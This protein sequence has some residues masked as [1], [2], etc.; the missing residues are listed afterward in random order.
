MKNSLKFSSLIVLVCLSSPLW[1]GQNSE[2][3]EP[4]REPLPSR[5]WIQQNEPI[6]P[7]VTS[8][9]HLQEQ[10]TEWNRRRSFL[11]WVATIADDITM[12]E[13]LRSSKAFRY[14]GSFFRDFLSSVPIT[15]NDWIEDTRFNNMERLEFLKYLLDMGFVPLH[16]YIDLAT[17]FLQEEG[18]NESFPSKEDFVRLKDIC[19]SRIWP[20]D[21]SPIS[22]IRLAI[23]STPYLRDTGQTTFSYTD[24][25]ALFAHFGYT[26]E[27]FSTNDLRILGQFFRDLHYVPLWPDRWVQWEQ[28]IDVTDDNFETEVLE[29]SHNRPVIVLSYASSCPSCHL[30]VRIM[31]DL[32]K[33]FKDAFTLAKVYAHGNPAITQTMSVNNIPAITLYKKGQGVASLSG[34]VDV[35]RGGEALPPEMEYV[36]MKEVIRDILLRSFLTI[37]PENNP[38]FAI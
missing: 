18:A 2:N 23:F 14:E 36:I 7:T 34:I 3:T 10:R 35:D 8:N 33:E 13:I 17:Y 22:L 28:V 30:I 38:P 9:L 5:S 20:C 1:A 27:D 37:E 21:S 11:Q 25:E 31:E 29:A 12:D 19:Q 4:V 24:L 6:L 32:A 26:S 16:P 15:I